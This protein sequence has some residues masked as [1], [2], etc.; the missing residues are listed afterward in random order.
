MYKIPKLILVILLI[1]YFSRYIGTHRDWHFIDNV[2]LIF[3]EAGHVVFIFGGQFIHILGGTI[4]QLAIPAICAIY[5]FKQYQRVSGS[6]CLM[7]LGQSF[8]NVSIYAGDAV[9]QNLELLGGSSVIHDWNYLLGATNLLSKTDLVAQII[10][11]VG[12]FIMIAGIVFSL[13]YTL[14]KDFIKS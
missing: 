7:W 6:I 11:S 3:H 14:E 1:G 5:F 4:M 12:I 9:K 8:I 10:Y 13:F 2:N